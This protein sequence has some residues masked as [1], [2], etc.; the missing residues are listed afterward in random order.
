MRLLGDYEAKSLLEQTPTEE[1][2]TDQKL[3]ELSEQSIAQA[4]DGAHSQRSRTAGAGR[5]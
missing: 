4:N 3:N 5:K 1:K 2:E